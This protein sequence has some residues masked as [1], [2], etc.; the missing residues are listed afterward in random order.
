MTTPANAVLEPVDSRRIAPTPLAASRPMYW[1]I[2]REL[3]EYR[4]IYIAPLAVAALILFGFMISMIHLPGKMRAALALDPMQQQEMIEQP[5]DFAAL[6][7]MATY[8]IV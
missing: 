2:R 5:Y 7:L 3:W 6:V 4:S 1:S 8:L